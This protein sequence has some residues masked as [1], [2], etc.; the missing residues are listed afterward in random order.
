MAC[1][2]LR[3]G[4]CSG[5]P[6]LGFWAGTISVASVEASEAMRALHVSIDGGVEGSG[7]SCKERRGA[8]N[9]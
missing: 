5:G 6:H 9:R 2:G 7:S 3:H 1:W 4:G 8:G